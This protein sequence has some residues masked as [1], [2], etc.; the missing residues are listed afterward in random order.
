MPLT[1]PVLFDSDIEIDQ[2][3][4]GTVGKA[5]VVWSFAESPDDDLYDAVADST[6]DVGFSATAAGTEDGVITFTLS[7]TA[8][9]P[10]IATYIF[11]ISAKLMYQNTASLAVV[12]YERTYDV[13]VQRQGTGVND[14]QL[15]TT[16]GTNTDS[17]TATAGSKSSPLFPVASPATGLSLSPVGGPYASPAPIILNAASTDPFYKVWFSDP[18]SVKVFS[19]AGLA[20]LRYE[21]PAALVSSSTMVEDTAD[22][23]I[24]LNSVPEALYDMGTMYVALNI[25]F[26][27]TSGDTRALRRMLEENGN[28]EEENASLIAEVKMVSPDSG[29]YQVTFLGVSSAVAGAAAALL[30]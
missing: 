2:A 11:S 6:A 1:V 18:A 9:A 5:W 13:T 16:G 20:T 29:S 24:T 26:R 25:N 3:N 10:R 19:D 4:P 27:D 28:G 14:Y 22:V 15:D 30:L 23:T 8:N 21:W 17:F 7:R 12:M